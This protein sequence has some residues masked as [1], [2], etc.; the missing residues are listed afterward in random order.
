[1]AFAFFGGFAWP[2]LTFSF[3]QVTTDQYVHVR[4]DGS[5]H[6]ERA[7]LDHRGDYTC[8]AENVVGVSNHTTTVNVYGSVQ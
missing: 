5:L 6:I 8:L 4:K 3:F 2:R 1:M 7:G